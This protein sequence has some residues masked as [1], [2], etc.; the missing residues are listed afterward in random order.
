MPRLRLGVSHPRVREEAALRPYCNT[1]GARLTATRRA[2][3]QARSRNLQCPPERTAHLR[4]RQSRGVPT[5]CRARR[6]RL[7]AHV[8]TQRF[9]SSCAARW[10]QVVAISRNAFCSSSLL[11]SRARRMNSS[12]MRRYSSAA[13]MACPRVNCCA[14][15]SIL[16]HTRGHDDNL[17]FFQFCVSDFVTSISRA[18]KMLPLSQRRRPCVCAFL[19]CVA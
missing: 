8:P 11:A 13:V 18:G 3:A 16:S 6:Y 4:L 12:A 9:P 17:P 1:D 10:L 19:F 2:L 14:P 5:A 15:A 7:R